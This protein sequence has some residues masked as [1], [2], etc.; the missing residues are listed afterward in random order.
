MTPQY[1]LRKSLCR[2]AHCYSAHVPGQG[3]VNRGDHEHTK[4]D[5]DRQRAR[6][7]ESAIDNLHYANGYAEPGYTDPAKSV[8]FANW[9]IFPRGIESV[10]ER[11]GYAIEWEDEWTTCNDCG[12]AVR[13]S[14]DS[15]H[16]QPYYVLFNECEIVCLDCV[17]WPDYLQSIEDDPNA[18]CVAECNPADH[19]YSLLSDRSEY[20]SGFFP[21]QTD[22]PVDV[23]KKLQDA[24]HTGIVF[25]LSETSQFYCKWEVYKRDTDDE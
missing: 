2:P 7:A 1:I 11:A 16:W 10:L 3:Y 9:N 14:G 25:R 15:Y 8:L 24:G 4:A 22:R 19:G 17:D 23:L 18:A 20:E 6:S 12:K 13:T 21:G 5:Y